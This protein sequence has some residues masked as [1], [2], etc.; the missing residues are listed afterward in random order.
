MIADLRKKL[1]RDHFA[2]VPAVE[3]QLA[4]SE[5]GTMTD[6]DVFAASWHNLP[7]DSFMADGGRYRQRRHAVF[8]VARDGTAL[9]EPHQPHYQSRDRN[10]LNGGIQ[11]WFEPIE[12]AIA[13]GPTMMTVLSFCR[14]LFGGLSPETQRWHVE[15][16]QF[17]IIAQ[18][19]MEGRPTP[20]GMHRD[21]VDY[22]LVML[23]NRESVKSGETTIADLDHRPLGSFTLSK[24]F[25]SA[26]VDDRLVYHGV[27][28][29]VPATAGVP[30]Y[31]DVLVVTWRD[32][33]RPYHE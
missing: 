22:V 24:P 12:P 27:T 9:R 2:L 21:G 15:A 25:D 30:A 14:S 19:G 28:P 18:E 33:D 4:F 31:R 17:R 10:P 11:R 8:Q 16:H 29:I 20:E 23:V 1:T 32:R 7:E 13:A 3:M 26:L 6:W 5:A